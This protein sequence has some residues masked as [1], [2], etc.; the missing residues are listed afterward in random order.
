MVKKIIIFAKNDGSFNRRKALITAVSYHLEN[1]KM[2]FIT[3]PSKSKKADFNDLLRAGG[4]K[5]YLKL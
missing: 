1:E 4:H 5:K 2:V 3:M